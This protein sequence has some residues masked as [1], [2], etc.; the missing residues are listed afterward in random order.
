MLEIRDLTVMR[1]GKPIVKNINLTV[2]KREV[3]IILGINGSGKTTLA[4]AIMG[5]YPS[6]GKIIF[7]GEDITNLPIWERARRGIT[8]AF[9]EPA[10]FEGLTVKEY[11]MLS[12]PEKNMSVLKE[13]VK[14]VG[15]P[16]NILFQEIGDNLSGGER[17]RIELASVLLMKPKLAILDEPDS[18]IDI[19]SFSLISDV[20]LKMKEM[21]SSVILI[22]HSEEMINIGDKAT[23]IC[24]GK[25]VKSGD[26]KEIKKLFKYSPCPLKG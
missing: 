5:I 14:T 19:L 20:I 11:L 23:I 7:E 24:G 13:A 12:S 10:R 16:Y 18:G 4:H 3:H 9:Q 17:K 26:S 6:Q 1:D 8:L 2:G 25:I 15:L 21:G 22:T